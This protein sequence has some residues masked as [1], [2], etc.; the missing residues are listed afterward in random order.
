MIDDA[1][2]NILT[3]KFIVGILLFIRILGMFASAPFFRQTAIPNKLKVMLA[4]I[5]ATMF[6]SAFWDEQTVI[7]FHLW[8]LVLLV[9]KEFLIGAAIGF[10]ANTVFWAARFAGGIIDFEMGYQTGIM[11][12]MEDTPTL[13]GEIKDLVTLMIFLFINGHHFLI[14]SLFASVRAVPVTYFEITE[15]SVTMLIRVATS[16][17][18]IGIKIAA[19]VLVSLFLANLGL[20]LMARVAPQTNIFVLSFQLKIVIG[21]L[22]LMASVPLFV[23]VTKYSLQSVETEL[24]KFIM[25]LNPARVP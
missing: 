22:V 2:I 4:V 1:T 11:F 6:T 23:M 10:V 20:V 12:S 17:L 7:D 14:E 25:T 21:I 24:M 15:S 9:F 13:V 19:P 16:V 8:Y 5:L 3:G 18:I